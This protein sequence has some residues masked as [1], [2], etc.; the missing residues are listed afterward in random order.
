MK[1]ALALALLACP[2]FSTDLKAK[3][4]WPPKDQRFSLDQQGT[5]AF[6]SYSYRLEFFEFHPDT[7]VEA[8]DG[9][10]RLIHQGKEIALSKLKPK[11]T[12]TFKT[13]FSVLRDLNTKPEYL[14]I[15]TLPLVGY[16]PSDGAER[17]ALRDKWK[18]GGI[19]WV[20]ESG[21]FADLTGIFSWDGELVY[22]F[23]IEQKVPGTLVREVARGAD[24]K[25]YAIMI[26]ERV[27]STDE[28]SGPFVGKPREVWTWEYPDK[29]R[30]F[31]VVGK[32]I[33]QLRSDFRTPPK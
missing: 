19:P 5:K 12:I 10:Q 21:Q 2:A 13:R 23:P 31:P 6:A 20:N 24:G 26:G 22:R 3:Q 18:P 32:E 25:Y 11:K 9:R 14:L 33:G 16:I 17:K 1:T 4:H 27:V 7:K 8:L 28:E 29:V 15:H 30:K